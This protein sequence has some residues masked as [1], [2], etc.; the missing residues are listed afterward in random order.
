[1]T[2]DRI[3]IT[4]ASPLTARSAFVVHLATGGA[5][6]PDTIHG[7]IEHIPSGRTIQ[8]ASSA[9]LIGFMQST[10]AQDT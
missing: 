6:T 7:R 1:M 5:D 3:A 8:F 9:E 4:P 2:N 10:L